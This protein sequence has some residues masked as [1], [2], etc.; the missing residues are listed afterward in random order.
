MYLTIFSFPLFPILSG[1]QLRLQT[2]HCFGVPRAQGQGSVCAVSHLQSWLWLL[3]SGH[4]QLAA[5]GHE[6]PGC[7]ILI[8]L[9]LS[10]NITC[11][12]GVT[13]HFWIASIQKYC[14]QF[15]LFSCL[16]LKYVSVN[17]TG[18][19]SNEL[20]NSTCRWTRCPIIGQPTMHNICEVLICP[21][22]VFSF[23]AVLFLF[24][25][26]DMKVWLRKKNICLSV[27][28]HIRCYKHVFCSFTT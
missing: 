2:E 12:R 5:A 22:Q 1:H 17:V 9:S 8:L 19:F 14:Q 11:C 21:V 6:R 23:S 7:V 18:V 26:L 15:L 16:F 3:H 25:A 28:Q 27:Q 13:Y 10:L 24:P 4:I 20:S